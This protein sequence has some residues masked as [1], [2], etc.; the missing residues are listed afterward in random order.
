MKSFKLFRGL[1]LMFCCLSS[2]A[3]VSCNNDNDDPVPSNAKD[4]LGDY[5]GTIAVNN[6]NDAIGVKIDKN[7][8]IS[9]FPTKEIVKSVVATENQEEAIK[10]LKEVIYSIDYKASATDKTITLTLNPKTLSFEMTVKGKQQKVD[11]T[12][13]SS[14]TG[15]Y[16]I[17]DK[18]LALTLKAENVSI[19]GTKVSS[20]NAL[21]FVL[22][23]KKK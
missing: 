9:D 15:S 7:V 18:S 12:F 2:L 5:T 19:D 23:A 11:V 16:S 20:F 21:N 6:N 3:M 10:S 8:A 17:T 22:S 14:A 13:T 4:V 1:L